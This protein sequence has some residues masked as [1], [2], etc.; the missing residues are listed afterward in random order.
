MTRIDIIARI[1]VKTITFSWLLIG[2]ATKSYVDSLTDCTKLLISV[3]ME[4]ESFS[5]KLH[6]MI[7]ISN[8]NFNE[9]LHSG[10]DLK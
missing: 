7:W 8:E 1:M 4:E 5:E 10:Q 2:V 6:L 9:D 3:S